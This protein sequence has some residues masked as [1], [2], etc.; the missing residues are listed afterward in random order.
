MNSEATVAVMPRPE[1]WNE[2]HYTVAELAELWNLDSSTVREWFTDEPGV[3]KHGRAGVN[4]RKRPY[5]TLRIPESVA[6]RVHG[7]RSRG[8]AER[9]AARKRGPVAAGPAVGTKRRNSA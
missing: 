2:R 6:K 9:E 8:W 7:E 5:V 4:S 3:L 1:A